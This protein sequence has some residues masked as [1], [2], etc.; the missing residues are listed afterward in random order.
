MR[1]SRAK[2]A[3][4]WR[5]NSRTG[6]AIRARVGARSKM[7]SIATRATRES[8]T[9]YSKFTKRTANIQQNSTTAMGVFS[10]PKIW[11]SPPMNRMAKAT[12]SRDRAAMMA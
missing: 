5:T 6:G 2:N 1:V 8:R 10:C 12:M 4:P 9:Q 3:T 7:A 11:D